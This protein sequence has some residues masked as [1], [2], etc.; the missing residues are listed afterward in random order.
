MDGIVNDQNLLPQLSRQEIKPALVGLI[1]LQDFLSALR[2]SHWRLSLS[3]VANH[4]SSISNHDCCSAVSEFF[5]VS[6]E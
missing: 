4:C 2:P 5:G 3:S 1:C 6:T